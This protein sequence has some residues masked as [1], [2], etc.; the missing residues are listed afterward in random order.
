MV[1]FL[2]KSQHV[3][4]GRFWMDKAQW[5]LSLLQLE[6]IKIYGSGS[7]SVDCSCGTFYGTSVPLLDLWLDFLVVFFIPQELSFYC[8]FVFSWVMFPNRKIHVSRIPALCAWKLKLKSCLSWLFACCLRLVTMWNK[9]FRLGSG[10]EK[11]SIIQ[12]LEVL[13]GPESVAS[14]HIL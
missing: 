7:G 8:S 6:E 2:K 12:Y 14:C 4:L 5:Q 10:V 1:L 13:W 9:L 3:P 11:V